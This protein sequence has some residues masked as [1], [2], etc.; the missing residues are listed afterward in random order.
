[1]EK[2]RQRVSTGF[3]REALVEFKVSKRHLKLIE[4]YK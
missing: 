4:I 1:M 3:M 2:P